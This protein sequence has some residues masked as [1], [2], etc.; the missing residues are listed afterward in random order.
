MSN[1][2]FN[3]SINRYGDIPLVRLVKNKDFE[4]VQSAL[5]DTDAETFKKS[6][7]AAMQS[8]K[9][10]MH[11][12]IASQNKKIMQIILQKMSQHLNKDEMTAVFQQLSNSGHNPIDPA[13]RD[14]K[15]EYG[16]MGVLKKTFRREKAISA[17]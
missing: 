3:Q 16:I 14:I 12:V 9:N 17:K 1:R 10:I 2:I 8:G 4:A 13:I 5:A 15:G 6:I 11:H 7:N